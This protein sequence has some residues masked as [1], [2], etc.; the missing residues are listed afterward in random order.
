M[1]RNPHSPASSAPAAQRGFSLLE[2]MIVI[3][4]IGVIATIVGA[5]IFGAKD[6][7][8][9]DLAKAQVDTIAQRIEQYEQDVG[10]LPPNLDALVK[11]PGGASGW[12]GPYAKETDLK[13]PWK[14]PLVY[15]VPGQSGPYDL[16]SYGRDG[17]AGG[18]SVDADIKHE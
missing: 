12:L 11:A 10:S 18:E 17:K 2:I 3:V 5:K 7:A 1:T 16:M 14:H 4:L 6:H 15:N 8:N 9:H 13:D